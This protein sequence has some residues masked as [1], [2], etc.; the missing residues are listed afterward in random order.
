L[1]CIIGSD[2]QQVYAGEGELIEHRNALGSRIEIR[3]TQR[4]G[5][6]RRGRS[7]D[8]T[9]FLNAISPG[10]S[11]RRV[12]RPVPV[13]DFS[14]DPPTMA[15]PTPEDH[16]VITELRLDLPADSLSW[17]KDVL[18]QG[19]ETA[20]ERNARHEA[21]AEA[22]IQ[23][24]MA[25]AVQNAAQGIMTFQ[26]ALR[27]VASAPVLERMLSMEDRRRRYRS[28]VAAAFGLPEEIVYSDDDVRATL[29]ISV[30]RSAEHDRI[31]AE[32]RAEFPHD[33]LDYGRVYPGDNGT[34]RWTPPAD[35][36]EKIRSCP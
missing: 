16:E 22:M 13:F 6:E 14:L 8:L 9:E 28:A 7:L 34:S 35:P 17:L 27:Q 21:R 19:F 20:E 18:E 32:A 30:T 4:V 25:P 29:D 1:I 15:V 33:P 36:D 10:W 2:R 31:I 3:Q 23:E 5:A 26:E 11:A 12:V 24:Q